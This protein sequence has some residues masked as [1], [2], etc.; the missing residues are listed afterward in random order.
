V[1]CCGFRQQKSDMCG[2]CTSSSIARSSV[3]PVLLY[4]YEF[5]SARYLVVRDKKGSWVPLDGGGLL[6]VV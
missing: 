5:S 2:I 4:Y 3:R 6:Q 1:L